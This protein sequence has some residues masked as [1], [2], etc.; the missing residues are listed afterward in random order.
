MEVEMLQQRVGHSSLV[1]GLK[2]K[3]NQDDRNKKE[4]KRRVER[5]FL[6]RELQ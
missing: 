5:Y 2:E 1:S 4:S 3:K 6:G